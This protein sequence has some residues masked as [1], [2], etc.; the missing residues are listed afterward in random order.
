[1]VSIRVVL[2]VAAVMIAA[3]FATAADPSKGEN[4]IEVKIVLPKGDTYMRG[5]T[6]PVAD[7]YVDVTLTNK[8]AKENRNK[9]TIEVTNVNRLT[10]E[11]LAQIHDDAVNNKL[12]ME[13]QAARVEKKKTTV[14]KEQYPVNKDSIGV[15]YVEPQLGPHDV[16][17]FIITKLPD[18]GEEAP[19][20]PKVI[21][22]DNKPE[23]IAKIDVSETLY[24]E[25][26]ESTKPFSLPVG[27]YYVI[28]E[29]GMYSIKAVMRL[30]G[31]NADGKKFA[32][33][34]EEKFRV[35]P[36]K[37]VSQ[38]IGDVEENWE[39]YERGY[40]NFD[41]M[42][43]QVKTTAT[44][45]EIYYVQRIPVRHQPRW[46]WKRLCTVKAGTQVQVAQIAPKKVA[47]LAAHHKGDA[48]LYTLDFT[49][50][51]SK[52]SSKLLDLKEGTLPKLKVE[53]GEAA[54]E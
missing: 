23:H 12:K 39:E 14:S 26:G 34:N 54:T 10:A 36:F 35:L 20:K 25:A 28:R 9:E 49:K 13:E 17:D 37:V 33:S 15:A 3:K 6:D 29:P 50:V 18:E 53:G 30:I 1:M 21:G 24:L 32:E 42:L 27:K 2:A 5:A 48:G 43:Y 45:D 4:L 8:T 41:Y 11:E 16:I 22:R 40:P 7:L 31:D 19:A 47:V 44:Y 52:V 38:K 51:G 46:E